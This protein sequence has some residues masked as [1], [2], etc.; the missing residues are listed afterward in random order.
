[1]MTKKFSKLLLI[2]FFAATVAGSAAAQDGGPAGNGGKGGRGPGG[3]GGNGGRGL[4]QVAEIV[5]RVAEETELTVREVTQSLFNGDTVADI[6]TANGDD[7]EAF[8]TAVLADAKTRLDAQVAEGKLT[9]EQ[10]DE[11]LT[12]AETD[13]RAFVFDGTLPV[14]QDNGQPG[15]G[16][17]LV[18]L[19]QII[20]EQAGLDPQ[21][22]RQ[23]LRDGKSLTA[24]IEEAGKD[25]ATVKQASIEAATTAINDAVTAG[26]LTQERAD[27]M[28]SN[29]ETVIDRMLSADFRLGRDGDFGGMRGQRG[30]LVQAVA[31]ATGLSA[32]EV[33]TEVEAGKTLADVLASKDITVDSFVETQIATMKT[34]LDA[35]VAD[36][37]M[38]QA[39][40]DARLELA[41]V[42]LTERLNGTFDPKGPMGE[43][44][45][46]TTPESTAQQS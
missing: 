19:G 12:N 31:E 34:R 43:P 26:T 32:E 14:G 2:A 18:E 35:Q 20:I 15:Q 42:E 45:P 44:A 37:S 6:L 27:E 11:R 22:V 16:R 13:L 33:R 23:N 10:A 40:A 46:M 1:M 36:G 8:V 5:Q 38:T 41:R 4:G 21:T 25:V 3:R 30:F 24:Q 29:L 9:Q 39:L 7:P 17:P 28:I